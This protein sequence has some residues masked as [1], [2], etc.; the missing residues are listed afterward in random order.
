MN[1]EKLSLLSPLRLNIIR[2]ACK[3]VCSVRVFITETTTEK[4]GNRMTHK[5]IV[6]IC[7]GQGKR[8]R[9]GWWCAEELVD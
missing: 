4:K 6:L 2:H 7:R 3:N 9:F 8:E 1:M 5:L